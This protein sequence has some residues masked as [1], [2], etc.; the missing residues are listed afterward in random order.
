MS[1]RP[2]IGVLGASG[3]VGSAVLAMLSGHRPRPGYRAD[4]ADLRSWCAGCQVVINCTG[5]PLAS[6]IH[7]AGAHYVDPCAGPATGRRS[8]GERVAV[9]D[10]GAMPGAIG[11]LPRLL[12]AQLD[13]KPARLSVTAG[14]LYRF[15]PAS[16]REFLGTRDGWRAQASRVNHA[17]GLRD[18]AWTTQFDGKCVRRLLSSGTPTPEQLIAASQADTAGRAQYLSIAAELIG[19]GGAVRRM[20][21]RTDPD[22]T[23]ATAILCAR[24]ALEGE[25]PAGTYSADEV[26]DPVRVVPRLFGE[27]GSL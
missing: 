20:R 23:A 10:A 8:G 1:D 5:H 16:A 4:F 2:V 14:G 13:E 27:E 18:S 6:E 24:A 15:T 19:T 21:L 3:A 11:L 22:L 9:Y 26:L 7:A 25:I 12:A 17:L